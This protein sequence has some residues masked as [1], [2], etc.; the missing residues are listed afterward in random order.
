MRSRN[1]LIRDRHEAV[2]DARLVIIATEGKDTERI[3][4]RALAKEYA[5]PRVHVCILQRAVGEENNS[6]PE[7]VLN[8]LSACRR[9]Y[10]LEA[11]DEMWLVIDKDRWTDEMLSHVALCCSK[12]STMHLALSNPCFEIWLILHLLDVPAMADE[13]RALCYENKRNTRRTDTYLKILLRKLMG[14]YRESE[15]DTSKLVPYVETAIERARALDA[16]PDDR[17]PQTLG[18]RV[19]LLAE[20]IM[21]RK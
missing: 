21:N 17:W 19:Y 12:D 20:S 18:T 4:F 9:N 8:Q 15:Y 14:S 16:N 13:E 7:H 5:N 11:D 2:R 1:S 6:S 3:Y 10:F